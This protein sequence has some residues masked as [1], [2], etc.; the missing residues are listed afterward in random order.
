M[1]SCPSI[2][3]RKKSYACSDSAISRA[4]E[5]LDVPVYDQRGDDKLLM[6]N[7]RDCPIYMSICLVYYLRLNP[8]N[9]QPDESSSGEPELK[10][11]GG[12]IVEHLLFPELSE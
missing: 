7:K 1:L 9:W 2:L 12:T 6:M 11:E 4:S 10:E 3:A 8:P 5:I